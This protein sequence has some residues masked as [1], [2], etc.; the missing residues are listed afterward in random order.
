MKVVLKVTVLDRILKEIGTARAAG[1]EIAHIIVSEAEHREL[2]AD[3]RSMANHTS[4]VF[5]RAAP[6]ATVEFET[7]EL[8]VRKGRAGMRPYIRA[9]SNEFFNGY[10]LYVVPEDYA[11][12]DSKDEPL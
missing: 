4:F 5:S 6:D 3:R 1:R 9:I 8:P 10:K 11:P 7:I 12:V 2:R